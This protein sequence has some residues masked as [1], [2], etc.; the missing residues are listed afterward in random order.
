MKDR[1]ILYAAAFLRALATGM[2]GVLL[3]VYLAKLKLGAT[4]SGV[5]IAAGLVGAAGAAV[6]VTFAGEKWER[7]RFLIGLALLT[8]GGGVLFALTRDPV[9]MVAAAFLGMVNGMGRDRGAALIL[10]Q[11][12]LPATASD[13]GRTR[14]FALYNVL[15]DAG[16]ALGAL[17]AA[18]PSV[19]QRLHW[20]GELS[21]FQ[22]SIGIYALL[23]FATAFVYLP[24]SARVARSAEAPKLVVSPGSR[25]ILWRICPLFA[26]DSLGGGFLTNAL[27]AYFFHERF[28]VDEGGLGV[29]FFLAR[30]ANALSHLA[31]AWLAKKIGLV[32]TMVFTHIPSSLLLMTVPFAPSFWV[33]AILFLLR[34]GLVEMDVPTRQSYVMAVVRPEERTFASGVTHLVRM[35]A[36]AVAPSF[37]GLFMKGLLQAAPL[38]IGAGLKIVYDFLLYAAFRKVEPPEEVSAQSQ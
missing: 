38:F 23:M 15:Q 14:V 34:E 12:I 11:A 29:L 16:H 26:L 36:W 6:L 35:G 37:A 31:A 21:A 33:A 25:R 10:E 13:E 24:L 8:G 30:V 7:K 32:N 28:G 22:V 9:F 20:T 19:L 27:L 5:I 18:T 3:G 17:L 1:R 2:I 4:L